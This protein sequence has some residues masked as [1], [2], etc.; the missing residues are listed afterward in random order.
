MDV[1]EQDVVVAIDEFYRLVNLAVFLDFHQSAE[2]SDA[3]V[4]MHHVVADL[5]RI[6][7]GYR[8]LLVALYLAVDAVTLVAVEN[9]ML[10]IEAGFQTVVHEPLVKHDA[11]HAQ[12]GCR[13]T[14]F[15]KNI[16]QTLYLR[17]V[18][19]QDVAV[20]TVFPAVDDVVGEH[21]EILVE[22][23]LRR[24]PERNS[25]GRGTLGQIVAQHSQTTL[26]QIAE[27]LLARRK[28]PCHL[29]RLV[30]LFERASAQVV[31]AAQD[32]VGVV[33]P[34]RRIGTRETGE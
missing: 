12:F 25:C 18:V 32:V 13:A 8:H 27:Q 17:S 14:D 7:F 4:D 31:H 29:L 10:G 33:E 22:L 26:R 30:A 3:V 2:A 19:G 6:E 20:V 34:P 24:S 21:L 5:Q 9:L 11:H 1:H 15:M 16:I 23:R 28:Q